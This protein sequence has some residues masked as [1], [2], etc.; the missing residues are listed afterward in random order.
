MHI[1]ILIWTFAVY[2]SVKSY[3]VSNFC[4]FFGCY[5]F[6]KVSLTPKT[7]H[8]SVLYVPVTYFVLETLSNGRLHQNLDI[9]KR[10]LW[11]RL[12]GT[13]PIEN[14]AA[15]CHQGN[16][17]G[18]YGWSSRLFGKPNR[19]QSSEAPMSPKHYQNLPVNSP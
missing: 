8:M 15:S 2:F 19:S 14:Q 5:A 18:N 13:Q 9:G 1:L 3:L 4:M 10:N 16:S 12:P 7:G 6:V 11:H 17:I